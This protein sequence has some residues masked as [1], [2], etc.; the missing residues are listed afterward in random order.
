ML[1][2]PGGTVGRLRALR[3]LALESQERPG[4]L[5]II[6][7]EMGH[8]LLLLLQGRAHLVDLTVGVSTSLREGVIKWAS[9][10]V[11]ERVDVVSSGRQGLGVGLE[12]KVLVEEGLF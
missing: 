8:L 1:G 12:G 6:F 4:P 9:E 2:L 5:P 11:D 7:G 3:N 10:E